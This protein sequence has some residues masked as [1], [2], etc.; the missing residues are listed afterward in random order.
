[1]TTLLLLLACS[2]NPDDYTPPD[3]TEALAEGE[4][5]AGEIVDEEGLTGGVAAEGRSGDYLIYNSRARFVIQGLRDGN[6]YVRQG[7]GVVDADVVR[8]EGEPGRDLVDEWAGMF[9][10]GRLMEPERITVLDDGVA[11]GRAVLCVEGPESPME[12]IT[13]TLESPDFIEDTGLW[14]RTEYALEADSNLLQVTTTLTATEEDVSLDPGDI[15]IGSMDI[16]QPWSPGTGLEGA[17]FPLPWTGFVSRDSDA[18]VALLAPPGETLDLP[19]S[20][21]LLQELADLTLGF[22]PAVDLPEGESFT[23]TRYYGVG[24][25]LAE[26]S[27]AW[28]ALSG[29]ATEA[30]AGEVTAP[31]GPVAG[32]RV[33]VLVDGAPFT[34]AVTGADGSF[35]ADVPAGAAVSALADG[36]GDGLFTDLPDGAASYSTY[37]AAAVTARELAALGQGS[38]APEPARGRGFAAEGDPLT[39]VEPGRL[40][41]ESDDGL[42]FTAYLYLTETDVAADSRLVLD[43]PSGDKVAAGWSRD[44]DLEILAEPGTYTLVVHRGTAWEYFSA[45]VQ[46]EAG[47][48]VEQPVSLAQAYAH[49]GWL[50]AD[51]HIH[52]ATSQDAQISLEDRAVVTAA[53]GV[54]LLFGT[55]HD[56]VTDYGPAL[57]A[58]GLSGVTRAVVSDEVSPPTRGHVNAYPLTADVAAPNNGALAWWSEIPPDT[59][60]WFDWMAERHPG[61]LFQ[62]NHPMD[63]GLAQMAGWSPGEIA[64]PDRW[65]EDFDAVEVLNSSDWEEFVP[66]FMDTFSRGL[67]SAPVGVSDSH[68]HMSGGPGLNVTFVGTGGGVAEYS[69]EA[70]VEAMTARRTVVSHGPFLELSIEPGATVVGQ[71][72]L[73]ACALGPSWVVVDELVLLENGE[74]AQVEPGTCATF[75]LAPAADAHFSVMARG[76]TDMSPVFPGKLPWALSSPILVDLDGDGWE[77]PLPPLTLGR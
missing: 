71:A 16:G 19:L 27:D 47:L 6:F 77:P 26:I 45:T 49:D 75:S 68:A 61:A 23:F 73:E 58:L 37:A 57:E 20:M 3:L 4:V 29:E 62:L 63:K 13:G 36:R 17:E 42:P 44:G 72:T 40:S 28:L 69:D 67:L 22:A 2:D 34:V 11:S 7:G 1:M 41:L 35:S 50:I 39:L 43:R 8:G 59:Q 21:S 33:N 60:T 5:R 74:E 48:T 10:L 53:S 54:Q 38:P 70:L 52:A 51:P 56:G 24:R 31:D 66:F 55:D 14:I 76:L 18:A 15:L 46:L 25:D 65:T 9:G 30:F 32:A 12:L 64:S